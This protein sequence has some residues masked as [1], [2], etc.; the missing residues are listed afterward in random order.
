M[1]NLIHVGIAGL[2]ILASGCVPSLFPLYTEQDVVFDEA[3]VGA[4]RTDGSKETWSFSKHGEKAY[5]LVYVDRDGKRG[6][7]LVH[8]VAVGESRFLDLFPSGPGLDAADFYK[9]HIL[10]VHTFIRVW[11]VSPNLRMALMVPDTTKKI[12]AAEPA[13][14]RHEKVDDGVLLTAQPKELQAFLLKHDKTADFWGD[15][16]PM[17]RMSTEPPNE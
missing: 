11:A 15:D 13:Q 8:L 2:L 5:T 1:R 10:P 3:L 16:S 9:C 14:L 7:F 17:T 12:L 4:W 6:E